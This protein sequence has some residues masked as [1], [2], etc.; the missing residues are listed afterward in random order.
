MEILVL[1]PRLSQA[2]AK[3]TV[4]A[5]REFV[6]VIM[7]SLNPEL[8]RALSERSSIKV[9][10]SDR[11]VVVRVK[12]DDMVALRAAVNSYL[13]WIQGIMEIGSRVAA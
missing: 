4:E 9:E 8:D 3:I 11:G 13:Y 2:E 5:S 1:E 6:S 7:T 12:A 10:A